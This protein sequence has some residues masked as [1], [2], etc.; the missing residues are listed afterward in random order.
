MK[1]QFRKYRFK[2][3]LEY[4]GLSIEV[5]F[6]IIRR[7]HGA[8]SKKPVKACVGD[9]ELRICYEARR[10]DFPQVKCEIA[11]YF[12]LSKPGYW[13]RSLSAVLVMVNFR[14]NLTNLEA[15]GGGS[16]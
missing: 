13:N 16:A 3:V 15:F 10:A 1:V 12:E 8:L 4:L 2:T 7:H 11:E 9:D 14:P 5:L 6:G